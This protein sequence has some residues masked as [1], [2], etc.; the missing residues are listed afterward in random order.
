VLRVVTVRGKI[1]TPSPTIVA[2]RCGRVCGKVPRRCL[3]EP[4]KVGRVWLIGMGRITLPTNLQTP[5]RPL[6]YNWLE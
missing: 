4:E 5:D 1:L 6:P 2:A 3:D